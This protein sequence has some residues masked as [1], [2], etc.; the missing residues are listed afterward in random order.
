[1]HICDESNSITTN[2]KKYERLG[3]NCNIHSNIRIASGMPI[4]VCIMATKCRSRIIVTVGEGMLD[5]MSN[6]GG[7]QTAI[8]KLIYRT[9]VASL[10]NIWSFGSK[11]TIEQ[12][13]VD[14]EL[15]IAERLIA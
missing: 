10:R 7:I 2:Y 11:M 13:K 8:T 9:V 6:D 14:S 15:R 1:M 3:V 12:C 5:T 4:C